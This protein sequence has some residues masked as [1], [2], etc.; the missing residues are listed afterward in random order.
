MNGI[1][2]ISSWMRGW[3]GRCLLL[4]AA[5]TSLLLVLF[6]TSQKTRQ[7]IF[8]SDRYTLDFAAIDC[9]TPAERPHDIFLTE[10]QYLSDLP[11][12]LH[13]LEDG[14]ADRLAAAFA[15]HPWV[16][17][18]ERV[19]ITARRQV[20]VELVFRTPQL[21]VVL[22]ESKSRTKTG[23]AFAV[24]GDGVLLPADAVQAGLPTLRGVHKPPA[25]PAGTAWEDGA[26]EA[27]ARTAHFLRSHQAVFKIDEIEVT[28]DGVL[29]TVARADSPRPALR[30]IWG[31]PPG[32]EKDAEAG[33]QLKVDR[34]L[35]YRVKPPGTLKVFDLRQPTAEQR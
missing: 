6:W 28:D 27:A 22:A 32:K 2:A 18:V 20:R 26:V 35:E 9:P 21:L 15:R 25:G 13:L 12:R 30:V 16:E 5:L 17:K 10:V 11:D 4:A 29:L 14:L 31:S 24:D 33:A 19:E 23:S 34:L 7:H 3:A 8:F 1:H